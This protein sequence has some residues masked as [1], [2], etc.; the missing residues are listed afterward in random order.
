MEIGYNIKG[1]STE[2]I[3]MNASLWNKIEEYTGPLSFDSPYYN[4]WST[5]FQIRIELLT[6]NR[7][8]FI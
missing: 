4:I 6:L 5:M 7:Y 2:S 8:R 1:K 3:E